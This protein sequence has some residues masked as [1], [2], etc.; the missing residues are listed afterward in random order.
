[1]VVRQQVGWFPGKSIIGLSLKF[2]IVNGTMG[3]GRWTFKIIPSLTYMK[4]PVCRISRESMGYKA[5]TNIF[6]LDLRPWPLRPVTLTYDLDLFDHDL[7]LG[8][9]FLIL[10]WKLEFLHLWPWPSN[11][12]KI[13]W[14]LMCV[15]NFRSVGPA[16][17]PAERKQTNTHTDRCY[18]K[19]YLFR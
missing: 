12:S 8:P 6:D 18:R 7:D 17:Q 15:P 13:W 19:Y 16:I 4:T 3:L 11:S 2:L 9:P 1:M 14:S 10:G 5:P